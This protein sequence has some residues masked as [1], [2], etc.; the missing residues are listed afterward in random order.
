MTTD[1]STLPGGIPMPARRRAGAR[2]ALV[3]A[4]A[5]AVVPLLAVLHSPRTR[6]GS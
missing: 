4:A 1:L 3:L 5:V 6:A 2:L